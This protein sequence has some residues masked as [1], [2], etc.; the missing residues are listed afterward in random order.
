MLFRQMSAE[1][2]GYSVVVSLLRNS[3]KLSEPFQEGNWTWDN[4]LEVQSWDN[5]ILKLDNLLLVDSLP[6]LIGN[7]V[8]HSLHGWRDGLLDLGCHKNDSDSKES[9]VPFVKFAAS[10]EQIPIK[11]IDR[12]MVSLI[13][14]V[15]HLV[16]AHDFLNSLLTSLH[17]SH[18]IFV[19]NGVSIYLGT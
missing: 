9:N 12:E 2:S 8:D 7:H 6:V 17:E 1:L 11:N 3:H 18:S 4:K 15:L 5:V 16:D 14:V 13:S 10:E 19:L